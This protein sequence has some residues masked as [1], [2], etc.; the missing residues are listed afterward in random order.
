MIEISVKRFTPDEWKLYSENA[1]WVCFGKIKPAEWDRIDFALMS[2]RGH[3]PTGYM[4]CREWDHETLYWQ[5]GGAFPG[6]KATS[7]S[8]ISYQ[9]FVD[10]CKARYKRITTLIENTNTPMLRMAMKVGFR[11]CGTRVFKG[12][13]LLEH[14]LEFPQ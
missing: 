4:T 2:M 14:L 13:I 3:E 7:V 5:F 9:A 11:I 10:Y 8:F 6:T 12:D 1:H